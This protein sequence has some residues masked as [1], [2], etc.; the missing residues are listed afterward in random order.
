MIT[1]LTQ[2]RPSPLGA[3]VA[4][5][6]ASLGCSSDP[7]PA[8]PGGSGTE[9][10]Y[11][12]QV[13][14]Y[15]PDETLNYVMLSHELDFNVDAARLDAAR[16]FPGYTGVAPIGGAVMAADGTA[17]FIRK[18]DVSDDLVWS[19]VGELNFGL[20]PMDEGNYMNF[21]FQSIKDEK[22]VYFYYGADKTGRAV[23]SPE[24]WKI[25]GS[26]EDTDLPTPAA[27]WEL[28]NGGNRTGMRDY[29]GPVVQAFAQWRE[30]TN[31]Y[32]D[33]SWLAVYDA[34]THAE[35]D[36]LEVPCPGL[37]Q[38]TRDERGDLYFSTTFNLPIAVLYGAGPAPCVV[39]VKANGT[40]DQTFASNDLTA[41]TGGFYGVN[42]RYLA[43]GKAVANV[44]HHDRIAGLD[45]EGA[46]DSD[47]A[48]QIDE[49]P[50]L[51]ELHLIDMAE[52]TSE[53]VTGFA[54][55][56]DV[57][58]YTTYQLVDGRVFVTVQLDSETTRS[59]VYELDL[60]TA[61]VSQIATAE[62]DIWE[63][64]RVR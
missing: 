25:L 23:W 62:G 49:D 4:L 63:M 2:H 59:S 12:R 52:G 17:P 50:T 54:D 38:T 33:S 6:L 60:D 40:L 28:Q 26:H 46:V 11:L 37:Q 1:S 56:H 29:T 30:E 8:E 41:W 48:T 22:S 42:F 21:Y 55:D 57:G 5:T 36:V 58:Y 24:E 18:Y 47:I 19:E 7:S 51:W 31:G 32:T 43:R 14:V 9:P 16:E 3:V 45:P 44:L 27:G 53:I 39:K 34:T 13:A 64:A 15:G 20:Y 10:L 61:T 35:K